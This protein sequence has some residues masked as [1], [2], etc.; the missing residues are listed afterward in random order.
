MD[1]ISPPT[2]ADYADAA[3]SNNRDINEAIV[4]KIEELEGEFKELQQALVAVT[5]QMRAFEEAI[6]HIGEAL[7]KHNHAVMVGQAKVNANG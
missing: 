4:K 6:V 5:D 7:E 3:A 1:D 2:G